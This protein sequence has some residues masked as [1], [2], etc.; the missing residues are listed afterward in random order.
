MAENKSQ[1]NTVSCH[2]YEV[3]GARGEWQ[4]WVFPQNK[5][6]K[7]KIKS[8]KQIKSNSGYSLKIKSKPCTSYNKERS[9]K[10]AGPALDIENNIYQFVCAALFTE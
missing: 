6:Q 5:K 9:R 10:L 1:E 8:K 4:L 3:L 7:A 2:H